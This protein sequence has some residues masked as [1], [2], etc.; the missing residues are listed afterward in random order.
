MFPLIEISGTP[1]ERG[2]AYGERAR[3]RVERSLANYARLF[4]FVGMAWEEA[5]RRSAPYRD[6][7]ERFDAALL[8]E[9]EGI[10]R[11][12]GRPFGEILALNARTEI[13]PASFLTGADMGECTA[14]AVTPQA[15]AT[16][17]TLLAQ[18]WDWVGSQRESLVL[19][20]VREGGAPACVTLTEAG[21]LAKIG[22]NAS[23]FG[24]CLNILRSVFDG[25]EP[26]IRC[27]CCCVLC[28][29]ARAVREA[30]EFGSKLALGGSSNVL[31]ADRGGDVASL[32]L[33]PKGVQVV[34]ATGGTLC[35]T[36]HYLHPEAGGWQAEIAPNLS[37]HSR[38]ERALSH[39]AMRPT[40]GVEDLKRLLRDESDGLPSVCR[41]PDLDLPPE[42]QLETVA[43]V[44]MELDRG[45]MHVA[46]DVPSRTDYRP[47][48]LASKGEVALA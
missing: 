12:A 22:F 28:S 2:R 27:M 4:A 24:V 31:C 48:A 19:L 40:Q 35:H 23:G 37:T 47:V 41:R 34:R 10:A 17:G 20:R 39:V 38:L 15:S 7:I 29:R 21:M 30:I 32:E 5:Q 16:G 36:N 46:P 18:N 14:V 44:I 13:M 9:M 45:L 25:G 43:S 11:G 3:D 1:F 42:A 8:E 6:V 33:S 26:G